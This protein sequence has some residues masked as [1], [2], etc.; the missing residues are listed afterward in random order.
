MYNNSQNSLLFVYVSILYI[1]HVYIYT[2]K[3]DQIQLSSCSLIM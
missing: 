1:I 3:Y 2:L